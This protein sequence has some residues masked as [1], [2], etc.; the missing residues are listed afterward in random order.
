MTSRQ[1]IRWCGGRGLALRAIVASGL[2]WVSLVLAS[3][4]CGRIGFESEGSDA[5]A[6]EDGEVRDVDGGAPPDSG[7]DAG[8]E[9]SD[10]GALDGGEPDAGMD[11]YVPLE[12]TSNGCAVAETGPGAA[13]A[14]FLTE[15]PAYGVWVQPPT[16]YAAATTSGFY[17]L[18]FDGSTFSVVDRTA[19]GSF[20]EAIWGGG[21]R[22]Y[23]SSPGTGLLVMQA[24]ADGTFLEASREATTLVEARR[25]WGNEI[26][27]FVPTGSAGLFAYDRAADAVVGDPLPPNASGGFTQAAMVLGDR[28]LVA[29]GTALR[30]ASF[31]GATFTVLDDVPV[32]NANRLWGRGDTVFHGGRDALTA[33]RLNADGR[34]TFIDDAPIHGSLRSLWSDGANVFVGTG[35][36]TLH[37][38][39][40]AADALTEIDST[41]TGAP[42]L[43]LTGDGRHL[44]VGN[45]SNGVVAYEGYGCLVSR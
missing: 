14:A 39:S 23:L 42:V 7:T 17:S 4:G 27:L 22:V 11:P 1:R 21:G 18:S 16:I 37:A 45:G 12:P 36:G 8:G 28:V 10:G 34:L 19:E 15:S 5:G 2:W 38:F 20:A 41:A 33:Y 44:Y 35:S 31:D 6:A 29:D 3:G 25:A 13:V 32:A 43:G 9:R 40:W 30:V 24:Q 26:H